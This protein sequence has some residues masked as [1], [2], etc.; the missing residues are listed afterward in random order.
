[1]MVEECSQELR[2]AS[3]SG[4]TSYGTGGRERLYIAIAA[5]YVT[6]CVVP[7]DLDGPIEFV[8]W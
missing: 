3:S 4:F 6:A 2:R 1:M 5:K 7:A 8:T